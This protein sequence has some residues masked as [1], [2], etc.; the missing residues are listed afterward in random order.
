MCN[1]KKSSG[2]N[3]V[4][5]VAQ[6]QPV[7]KPAN[8]RTATSWQAVPDTL[9]NQAL[10]RNIFYG[11]NIEDRC[12]AFGHLLGIGEPVSENVLLAAMEDPGYANQLLSSRE[13]PETL[14][15]LLGNPPE[16]TVNFA[17]RYTNSELIFRAGKSLMKWGLSGFSTVNAETL[18]KREAACLACP[19]LSEPTSTLQTITASSEVK[20]E[21]GKRTGNK[22]CALCGCVVKNK[23]RI[24]TD[25]CPDEVP[26]SN[27]FN[28]WGERKR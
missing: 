22:V 19:N 14:M 18:Q 8:R 10:Q 2:S 21:T 9:A 27:G 7:S 25:T 5:T 24:A 26:G 4:R 3:P 11:D 1:C 6:Q 20:D 23:M 13:A 17:P 16:A 28:R 12:L 15:Y